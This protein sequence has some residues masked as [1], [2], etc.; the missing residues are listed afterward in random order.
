MNSLTVSG[1]EGPTGTAAAEN[2]PETAGAG[3]TV[4]S[5][6]SPAV[7]GRGTQVLSHKWLDFDAVFFQFLL[8]IRS[9]CAGRLILIAA[10]A[11]L[12]SHGSGPGWFAI[13]SLYDSCIRYSM[14]V[15]PGA[16]QTRVLPHEFCSITEI[17]KSMRHYA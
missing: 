14:P 12:P 1:C 15:Y 5:S 17:G 16:I 9:I 3:D 8:E 7:A 13:P 2:D 11:R 6:P 4:T 10:A